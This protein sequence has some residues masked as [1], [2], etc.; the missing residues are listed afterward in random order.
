ML[1]EKQV[2]SLAELEA[3]TALELPERELMQTQAGLVNLFIGN[4]AVV[5]PISVAANICGLQV[6]ALSALLVQNQ[7][8]TCE[9]ASTAAGIPIQVQGR[10][11]H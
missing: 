2:L 5:V 11:A 9:A 3:Q 6:A 8:T 1:A 4:L 10:G 7:R